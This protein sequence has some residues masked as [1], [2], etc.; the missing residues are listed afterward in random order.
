MIEDPC[1]LI[2]SLDIQQLII[3]FQAALSVPFLT[4]EAHLEIS[5]ILNCDYNAK[6]AVKLSLTV[7]AIKHD[8]YSGDL[9]SDIYNG[10]CGKTT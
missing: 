9:L 3:G 10:L 7:A 6:C 8:T 5:Y 4:T 2:I 1:W